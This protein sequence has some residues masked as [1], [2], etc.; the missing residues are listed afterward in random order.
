MKKTVA[1]TLRIGTTTHVILASNREEL[2]KLVAATAK[3]HIKPNGDVCYHGADGSQEW[4]EDRPFTDFHKSGSAAYDW[5]RDGNRI[6]CERIHVKISGDGTRTSRRL[7][8][9]YR[10]FDDVS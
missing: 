1:T 9:L 2:A 6:L 3:Q 7:R 8:K 10:K 5:H 4:I